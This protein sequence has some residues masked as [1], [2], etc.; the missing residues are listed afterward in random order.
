MADLSFVTNNYFCHFWGYYENIALQGNLSSS[1]LT[2]W[3]TMSTV[4]KFCC[5]SSN[6]T[7]SKNQRNFI[8]TLLIF[9][10]ESGE[11]EWVFV[12]TFFDYKLQRRS[13]ESQPQEQNNLGCWW[14]LKLDSSKMHEYSWFSGLYYCDRMIVYFMHI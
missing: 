4:V 14:S 6:F 9:N 3:E 7:S 1:N 13:D 12:I 5:A 11:C 8:S 10:E 2:F